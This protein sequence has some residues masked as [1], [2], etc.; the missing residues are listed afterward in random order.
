MT[1][2]ILDAALPAP[3]KV[4]HYLFVTGKLARPALE[5]V[6]KPLAERVGFQYQVA[7]LNI[8]VAAL[9][10]PRWVCG[11]LV[12]PAPV[13]AIF[14]P[15]SCTG[16]W[17]EL[18]QATG[19][20]IRV[21]PADLRDLPEHFGQASRTMVEQHDLEIIA[22]INHAPRLSPR[23]LLAAAQ[24]FHREGADVIDLGC[25]P[26]EPWSGIGEAVQRLRDAGLRVSVDS[27][28]PAEVAAAT[29]AGAE[30][31][32][33]VN[34]TNAAAAADWGCE[35]VAIPDVPADLSSLE[36]TVEKL[37]KNG[38]PH[39]LDPIL[40][41]IGMGFAASLGRYLDAR[42][43]FPGLEI[44]MGV[45]NLTEMSEVDSAGVN[46]LLAGFCQEQGIR[47]V[48]TTAVANW[49]SSSVPELNL[50]RKLAYHAVRHR[51]VPKKLDPS[52]LLLRDRKLKP[53]G[54][55]DLSRLAASLTDPNFRIFA[56][57]G[58][59]HLMNG[60]LYLRGTDP[61]RLM[62][63]LLAQ[64]PL[65]ADHAFYLGYEMAKAAA[66]LALGKNYVQD[67]PLNFGFLTRPEAGHPQRDSLAGGAC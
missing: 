5:A 22:E 40:E 8:S 38:V 23:D 31:V 57:D 51:V 59:L 49:A 24:R 1:S 15:G 7:M 6:L 12:V 52:L 27:F 67:Q 34:G 45:G 63:D 2:V 50:A 47:S 39:R 29:R 33:S 4:P 26:G 18:A 53:R 13:D 58:E 35:V 55:E 43:R 28:E 64:L 41:P 65:T 36:T 37:T 25:I 14:V 9:M 54:P 20:P 17:D 60:K 66:A 10:T 3:S 48:L 11:H 30:L 42:L 46:L 16:D 62:H 19:R 32:L 56:E 61:Y 21:G 44:M